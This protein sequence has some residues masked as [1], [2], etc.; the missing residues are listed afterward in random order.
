MAARCYF[1]LDGTCYFPLPCTSGICELICTSI[2]MLM[3]RSNW[4]AS[5][6]PSMVASMKV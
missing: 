5:T 4:M 3:R 1:R 6:M 2:I